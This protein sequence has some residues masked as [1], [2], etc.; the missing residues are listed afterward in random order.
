M[1]IHCELW[2]QGMIPFEDPH[3]A[4]D[5]DEEHEDD[6]YADDVG[7]VV[8]DD[9]KDD[10]DTLNPKPGDGD[11]YEGYAAADDR[12]NAAGESSQ[13]GQLTYPAQH[14]RFRV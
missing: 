6:E 7:G 3:G 10:G 13:P 8:D 12:D 14:F 9:D 2:H 5:D 4:C 1:R 11:D